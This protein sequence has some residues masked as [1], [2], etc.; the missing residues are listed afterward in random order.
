MHGQENRSI[1]HRLCTSVVDFAAGGFEIILMTGALPH[2]VIYFC[3]DD[4]T[5]STDSMEVAALAGLDP[6]LFVDTPDAGALDVFPDA[7]VIGVAGISRSQRPE[8]MDANLPAIFEFLKTTGGPCVR[9]KV[10][11]TF[12]SSPQIG[13]MGRAADI[14]IRVCGNRLVPVLVGAPAL[15]RYLSFG[16]LFATVQGASYRIDRHPVMSR[17]PITPMHEADLRVHLGH[18]THLTMGLVD[19]PMLDILDPSQDWLAAGGIDADLLFIDT[20]DARTLEQAGLLAWSLCRDTLVFALGSSGFEYALVAAWRSLGLL[21]PAPPAA[22]IAPVER[23]F[24]VSGSCSP[25][26]AS[27]IRHALANGFIGIEVDPA[28]LIRDTGAAHARVRRSL[29]A[30]AEGRD[31]LIYTALGPET[32]SPMTMEDSC[33]D[34]LGAALGRILREVLERAG[35]KRAVVAGGET[36]SD[37]VGQLGLQALRYGGQLAPGSPLCRTFATNA[38]LDGLEFALKGGQ[39]GQD[40]FF[41]R[42]KTG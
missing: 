38:A 36:F 23:I 35:L 13:N 21:P 17:H 16:N 3:G 29:D 33:N 19:L 28:E 26:T 18:Q 1:V 41:T 24:A 7:R 14:G 22:T 5:G 34:R 39:V 4:F 30:L 42:V 32:V 20:V 9:Y 27:Q 37:A 15:K 12:D 6:V 40:D 31:V 11:S 2:R 25:V 10:C 8:W